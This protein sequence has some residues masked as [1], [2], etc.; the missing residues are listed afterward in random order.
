MKELGTVNQNREASGWIYQRD[1]HM[2]EALY[3]SKSS[4]KSGSLFLQQKE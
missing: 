3:I 2:E 1:G 4:P